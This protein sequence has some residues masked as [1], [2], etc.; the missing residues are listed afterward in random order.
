MGC[1]PSTHRFTRYEHGPFGQHNRLPHCFLPAAA[2]ARSRAARSPRRQRGLSCLGRCL[3]P[4]SQ[5]MLDATGR[6]RLSRFGAGGRDWRWWRSV[7]EQRYRAVMAVLDGASPTEVAAEAGVSRQSVHTW[8]AR[9]RVGGL[10]GLVNRSQRPRSSPNQ[11][12][13]EVEAGLLPGFALSGRSSGHAD[14]SPIAAMVAVDL[15][16]LPGPHRATRPAPRSYRH[17]DRIG[18]D[19]TDC[20]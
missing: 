14:R 2:G 10:A 1:R 3:T 15:G 13:S 9:Y 19:P 8:V 17:H 18:S 6:D 20:A 7:V 16:H 11:A 4:E 12:S 5:E